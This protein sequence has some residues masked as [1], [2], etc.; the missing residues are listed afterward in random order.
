MSRIPMFQDKLSAQA[1]SSMSRIRDSSSI[2]T[3]SLATPSGGKG[4]G[5]TS[6]SGLVPKCT[7]E[8]GFLLERC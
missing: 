1:G 2:K 3:A 6:A 7:A 4:R 8:N 5:G